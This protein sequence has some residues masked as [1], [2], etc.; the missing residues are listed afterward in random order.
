MVEEKL[1]Q[2][3]YSQALALIPALA[4]EENVTYSIVTEKNYTRIDCF[5][6]TIIDII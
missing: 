1:K 3:T 6:E 2:E 4:E 5:I